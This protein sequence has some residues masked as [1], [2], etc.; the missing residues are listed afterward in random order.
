MDWRFWESF[1][2]WAVISLTLISLGIWVLVKYV[3]PKYDILSK[4]KNKGRPKGCEAFRVYFLVS[5]VG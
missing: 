1:A 4:Y 5:I 2:F 3:Y